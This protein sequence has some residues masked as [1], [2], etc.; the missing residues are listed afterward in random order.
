MAGEHEALRVIVVGLDGSGEAARALDWAVNVGRAQQSEVIAVH[1]LQVPFMAY[2]SLE[3]AIPAEASGPWRDGINRAFEEEWSRPLK[4]SGIRH[5]TVVDEGRPSRVIA[6]LAERLGA[7]LVVVGRRGR[8]GAAELLLGSV[9]HELTHHCT[10]PVV[11]IPGGSG[12]ASTS[13][14]KP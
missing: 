5:R 10:V 13:P 2:Y 8:G 7:D 4:E 11:V 3:A 6:D 14:S 1:A 12:E 9:S